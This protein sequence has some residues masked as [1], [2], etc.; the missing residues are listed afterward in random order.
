MNKLLSKT[1][2]VVASALLLSGCGGGDGGQNGGSGNVVKIMFHVDSKSKEG[3]AYKKR[4]DAFNAAYKEQGYRA[5]AS[6][7][8][9]TNGAGDYGQELL[10]LKKD[11][12]LPSI[13]TFDAPNCSAYAKS[14]ILYDI[15]DLLDEET[16][17]DFVSTSTYNGKLYGLP[18]Q[19]SSA[20]FFYNKNIFNAAGVNVSGITVENPWTFAEFKAACAKL[21]TYGAGIEKFKAVDMRLDATKDETAPYLLY[22]FSLATG[23]QYL[24]DDGLHAQGY[25]NSATTKAGFSFLKELYADINRRI[26]DSKIN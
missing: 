12:A 10:S 1:L 4:I 11:G 23:G 25:L 26:H 2:L 3:I 7:K 18:I 5:Q 13:I 14:K 6:Y 16:V 20:G 15:T 9:R 8:A 19:E 17:N 24:S 22:P 21:K